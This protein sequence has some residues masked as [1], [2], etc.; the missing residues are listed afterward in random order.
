MPSDDEV[1]KARAQRLEWEKD[2][3]AEFLRKQPE[4]KQRYETLSG[5]P[6]ERV[7]TP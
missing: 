4:A 3:L 6:V 5:I 1:Q 7:Y 2:E